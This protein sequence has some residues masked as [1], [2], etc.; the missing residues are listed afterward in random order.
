MRSRIRTQEDGSSL[1]ELALVTPVLL[2]LLVGA[3]DLGRA[4]YVAMEV[5]SA[6]QAGALYGSQNPTDTDGMVKAAQLDASDIKD[7]SVQPSPPSCVCYG[8]DAQPCGATA[9][10]CTAGNLLYLVQVNT[11]ATYTPILSFG[12][13]FSTMTFNGQAKMRAAF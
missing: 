10:P 11:S 13:V 3:V 1:V 6:A 8:G 2:L 9:N 5:N 12:G 7:I 4:Y